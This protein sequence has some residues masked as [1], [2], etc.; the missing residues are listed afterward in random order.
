MTSEYQTK[1]PKETIELGKKLA[2]RLKGGD[3]VL[4]YG[5]LGSGKTHFIK[6]IAEGLGIKMTIKSPTY[7]YVNKYP[8]NNDQSPIPNDQLS[9]SHKPYLYHYDLY[10]MEEG[11]DLSSIGFDE[12]LEDSKA[13]NVVEWA[14]RMDEEFL[15]Q[16]ITVYL[17]GDKDRRN[18]EIKFISS[19]VLDQEFVESY[20]EEWGTPE[21]VREH[22]KLVTKVAMQIAEACMQKGEIIDTNLLHTACM[23]HDVNRVCDFKELKRDR[24]EEDVTDEKWEKW[25]SCRKQFKGMHHADITAKILNE[26]DF[27]ETAELIRLHKSTNIVDE[28]KAYN[29]LEKQIIYYADKRVAHSKIV[30]LAERFRDGRER[31]EKFDAIGN[32]E[33]FDEVEKRT[34]ELEKQLF[35]GLDIDSK[36][37]K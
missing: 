19:A 12:S 8:L 17:E 30:D 18:I 33:L 29:A 14:D 36:D 4:L 26:R 3:V 6:G 28:P 27:V 16:Y 7:A 34:Y 21:H 22:C 5:E 23:L 15:E 9:A 32:R 37:I 11:G 20:Y 1:S 2:G 13:I 10:R 31:Y 24:F 25:E 35:E